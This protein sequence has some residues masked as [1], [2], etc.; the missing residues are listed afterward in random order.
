MFDAVALQLVAVGGGQ[1]NIAEKRGG[2][3]LADDLELGEERPGRASY[4]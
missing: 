4:N 3:D 2:D 1:D